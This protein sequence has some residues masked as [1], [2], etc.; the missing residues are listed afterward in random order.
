MNRWVALVITGLLLQTSAALGGFVAIELDPQASDG[1]FDEPANGV[2]TFE[3]AGPDFT[4]GDIYFAG[5]VTALAPDTYANELEVWITDPLGNTAGWTPLPGTTWEDE[6][7]ISGQVVQGGGQYLAGTAGTW[8]FTFSERF[9]DDEVDALWTD[10]VFMVADD[11]APDMT[12][13]G[14]TT[15]LPAWHR[16]RKR[17]DYMSTTATGV[18]RYQQ[19]FRV[20]ASGP[21]TIASTHFGWDGY[22]L[23]YADAP[24]DPEE[25]FVGGIAG[26]D[27]SG[28]VDTTCALGDIYLSSEHIYWLYVTGFG[29]TDAGPFEVTFSGP[30]S[31]V[32]SPLAGDMD[33][34][35]LLTF[36]DIYPFIVALDGK[37]PYEQQFSYCEWVRGDFDGDGLVTFDDIAPFVDKLVN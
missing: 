27:A 4:V 1:H 36:D 32:L 33:C 21:Y 22:L 23:L 6:L 17:F 8:T 30:G 16:P 2:F 24:A 9:D 26:N 7:I 20:L 5:T 37:E 28:D 29:D 18:P 31:V 35:G 11:P 10:L 34:D 3:Y 14:D 15:G 12:V 19:H 13:T 25:P